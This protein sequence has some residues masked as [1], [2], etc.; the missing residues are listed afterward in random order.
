MIFIL[1]LAFV[2]QIF[3]AADEES[4][5]SENNASPERACFMARVYSELYGRFSEDDF[6]STSLANIQDGNVEQV[7]TSREEIKK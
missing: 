7:K 5:F 2:T 1:G 6:V 4:N 3:G